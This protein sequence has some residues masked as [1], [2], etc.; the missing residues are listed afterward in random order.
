MHVLRRALLIFMACLATSQ[1]AIAQD[2]VEVIVSRSDAAIEVFLAM[3]ADLA[4]ENF[5]IS[6]EALTNESGYADFDLFAKG[7]FRQG[8]AFWQDTQTWMD[9]APL[10]FEAMS[11]MIHPVNTPL[12]FRKPLDAMTAIEVCGT[13]LEDVPLSKTRLYVGLIAYPNSPAGDLV[14]EFAKAF[15]PDTRLHLRDF[16]NHKL[17][18]SSQFEAGE[19]HRLQLPGNDLPQN[20]HLRGVSLL[21][22]A[23]FLGGLAY[24][25][26]RGN[27]PFAV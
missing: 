11:L 2:R 20:P 23:S 3:P 13:V 1:Q 14:I 24:I 4:V 8:Q 6:A 12:P 25:G 15:S 9:G 17:M 21:L 10:M 27:G 16:S 5:G 26:T 22:I 19:N 18:H 7:T